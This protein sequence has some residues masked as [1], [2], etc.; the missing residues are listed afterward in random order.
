MKIFPRS[1]L[2]LS[3]SIVLVL[4]VAGCKSNQTPSNTD[5]TN[6]AQQSSSQDPAVT[7]IAPIQRI[8]PE[9]IRPGAAPSRTG[10]GVNPPRRSDQYPPDETG[11]YDD[12]YYNSTNY[13]YDSYDQPVDYAAQPPPPLPEYDQPPCPGDYYIWTPGY[14]SYAS[15]GYYWV[16]GAWVYAPYP[17][18][19]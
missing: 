16:P 12:N 10:S 14:W 8:H 18:A 7:N 3:L 6:T 1:S 17:G 4:A 5:T 13:D 2:L 9:R 19:L 15:D 11:N